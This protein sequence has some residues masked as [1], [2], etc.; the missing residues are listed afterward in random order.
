LKF[1]F[2]KKLPQ[3][4]ICSGL[5]LNSKLVGNLAIGTQLNGTTQTQ[6]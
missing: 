1:H 2:L 4:S 5:G 3:N 6:S